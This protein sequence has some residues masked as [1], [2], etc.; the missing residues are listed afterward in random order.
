MMSLPEMNEF[1]GCR[2]PDAWVEAALQD[3]PTLLQDH[4]NNEKKAAGAAFHY[5]FTYS[6]RAE[7]SWKMSRIAR[8]EL[9]HFEQVLQIMKRRGIEH[10]N[11]SSARYAGAL[12]K[13]CRNHEPLKLTDSLVIGAFIECRSCER[14]GAVA[15][16]L[17]AELG[18]FYSG[19]LASEARH[20]QD[21]LKLAYLYGERDDVDAKIAEVRALEVE[22]ITS[23]DRELRFHSGIPCAA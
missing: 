3:L 10:R 5:L 2:T 4:A 7:L 16:H 1:L 8:E 19:L 18:K 12:R 13:L 6:N 22:L 11:V 23:S 21:Y 15:P 14:F 9:R 20:F 17:D